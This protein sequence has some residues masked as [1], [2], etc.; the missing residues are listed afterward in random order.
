MDMFK[1]KWCHCEHL[2]AVKKLAVIFLFTIILKSFNMLATSRKDKNFN[3][4]KELSF[5]I[6]YEVNNKHQIQIRKRLKN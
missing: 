3:A 1:N 2:H 6:N 4:E 5:Y